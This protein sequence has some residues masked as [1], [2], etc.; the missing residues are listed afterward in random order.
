MAKNNSYW[1]SGRKVG[2]QEIIK[3]LEKL[4]R[5]NGRSSLLSIEKIQEIIGKY[6]NININSD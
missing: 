2:I 4:L 5:E 3:E 6:K 1:E